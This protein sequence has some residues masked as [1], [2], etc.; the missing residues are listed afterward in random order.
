LSKLLELIPDDEDRVVKIIVMPIKE[1]LELIA[2]LEKEKEEVHD[3]S[4]NDTLSI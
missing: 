3:Q 4:S 1:Q 2:K